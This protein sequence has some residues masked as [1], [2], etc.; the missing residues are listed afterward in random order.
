MILS[1]WLLWIVC[2]ESVEINERTGEK[3]RWMSVRAYTHFWYSCRGAGCWYLLFW[4]P[5]WWKTK[6]VDEV[7]LRKSRYIF[8]LISVQD[9][10][11]LQQCQRLKFYWEMSTDANTFW[12]L[13]FY[14]VF[15]FEH[16]SVGFIILLKVV[17]YI[18]QSGAGACNIPKRGTPK[19][20]YKL[21]SI[22]SLREH[23]QWRSS[24]KFISCHSQSED[25][26]THRS[27][28]ITS[29]TRA[30]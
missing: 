17:A 12:L 9:W 26:G 18:E 7:Y 22:K 30:Q 10:N 25:V 27:R 21:R 5:T 3:Y 29:K 16:N 14:F 6:D 2:I 8:I 13:Q 23:W 24:T 19:V 1:L 20:P 28:Y 4:L 15:S 11:F